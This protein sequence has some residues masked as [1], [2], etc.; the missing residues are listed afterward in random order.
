MSKIKIC[1][2]F[3]EI[4][5]EYVNNAKPDFAGFIMDFPKSHRSINFSMAK[6]LISRLDKSIKSVCVFVDKPIE[7]IEKFAGTCDIIQLHGSEDDDYIEKLRKKMSNTEIW[8]AY[9][10]E[11]SNDLDKAKNS[12]ADVVLLDNGYGTG[13]VFDW[14][15]I[16]SVDKKFILAGG[17]SAENI[18]TAIDK[19]SPYAVDLSSSVETEKMKNPKK[20]KEIIDIVRS[21]SN[22]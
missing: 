19:F 12:I 18:K 5:I 15:I 17:I 1:G 6:Y 3:R 9:K 14:G 11:N 7:Y 13:E 4:D 16:E 8:K 10:I 22:E 2:L 21:N 20:I